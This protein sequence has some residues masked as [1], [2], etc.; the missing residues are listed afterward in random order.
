MLVGIALVL[1]QF[2]NTNEQTP[3]PEPEPQEEPAPE[4]TPSD[5]PEPP[6]SGNDVVY[7]KPEQRRA[8]AC[9]T[10]YKP[11]CG[12]VNV[13]CIKEPCPPL[14]QTYGNSCEA[15]SNELVDFYTEGEC[16]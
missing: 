11:V 14:K 4:P 8:D 12:N 3:Q 1:T 15:C 9:I 13:Q 16:R 2:Q 5:D 7:C 6:N 10:L